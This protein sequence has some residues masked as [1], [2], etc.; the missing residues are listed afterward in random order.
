M[1]YGERNGIVVRDMCREDAQAFVDAERA[2]GWHS[3]IGKFEARLR[4]QADGV[5][6][7]LVAEYRGEAAGYVH[8]YPVSTGGPFAGKGWPEIVDF[9]VLEKFRGR[10]IGSFLMDTAEGLAAG[11]ADTVCL[12]VGLHSGYGSAQRMYVKRGYVPDGSGA[13]YEDRPGDPYG[14]CALDDSLIL[15]MS[16]KL[17]RGEGKAVKTSGGACLRCM[18]PADYD[19]VHELWMSC[20]NMG[21]NDLDDSREGIASFLER[22]PGTCFVAECEGKMAGVI[23]SG[24]DGRRGYIYHMAVSGAYR[25]RGIGSALVSM[26][27]AAL[28]AEGIHK[29]ALVVFARNEDGNAFWESEG[30]TVREDLVYRNRTLTAMVRMDT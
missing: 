15:H 13:W 28:K 2:Q 18:E 3:E 30:F 10:G 24:H 17:R 23:L 25:R 26:V 14:G 21:L 20:R 12:G 29:V 4:D 9:A 1:I 22:N 16:K 19:A 6:I 27:L 7:S 8:L 11:Y 5:C